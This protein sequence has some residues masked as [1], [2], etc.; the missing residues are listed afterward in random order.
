MC[1]SSEDKT[2]QLALALVSGLMSRYD[3]S[4]KSDEQVIVD[5]FLLAHDFFAAANNLED[6]G[7]RTPD[8]FR[9]L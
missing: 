3:K 9:D 5:A 8:S 6:K 2:F 1:L 4:E 7:A